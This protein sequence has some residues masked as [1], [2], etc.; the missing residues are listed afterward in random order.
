MTNIA[1]ET[2]S[3][4]LPNDRSWLLSMW[5]QGPGE[6]P[7]VILDVS[8]F[9]AI[10]HFPNGFIK[11][12]THLGLITAST[13][14]NKITVGPY[15]DAAEDGRQT[16]WGFLHSDVKVPNLADLTKDVGAAAVVMGCVKLAKLPFVL[17]ANGKADAK[18][19][20]FVA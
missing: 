15:D 18:L 9:T 8:T 10:T 19:F 17:D 20:H 2:K 6:N 1:V 11:S 14:V 13:D 4:E 5:G 3:F 7:S 12:G 16:F